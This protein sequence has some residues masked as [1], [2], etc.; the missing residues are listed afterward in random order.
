MLS[1]QVV[2]ERGEFKVEAGFTCAA[3]G[4]TALFGPS[5]S[6]KT[7]VVEMVAGLLRPDQGRISLG[8]RVFF[9]S[10]QGRDLPPEK[11]RLGYIFQEARLFPHLSVAANLRYGQ[12]LTPRTE[13]WADFDQVVGLLGV[14]HLLERR[15]GR[16][17]G[18]EKQRVAL[19]RALLS[20][21]RLLLMDEPLASVDAAR[22]S[23][24]LPFIAAVAREYALPILYISHAPE[25]IL[26]LAG[27]V[28]PMSHGRSGPALDRQAWALE[29]G[30][31]GPPGY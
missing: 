1:V 24:V 18:G 10:A 22:K 30:L 14:G 29:M 27:T 13:R 8:E 12:R 16:L 6:G 4:V 20:S 5:G 28:V 21:P 11:R 26:Q 7:S 17:S 15:P 3:S 19:G 2:K 25:E 31:P 23:E 9:D